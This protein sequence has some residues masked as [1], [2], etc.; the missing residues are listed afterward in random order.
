MSIGTSSARTE[1]PAVTSGI[2]PFLATELTGFR[3]RT[4]YPRGT[5]V[6]FILEGTEQGRESTTCY[7]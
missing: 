5:D 4:D 6:P 2:V 3:T 1:G 7:L